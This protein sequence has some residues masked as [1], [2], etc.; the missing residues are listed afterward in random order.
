MRAE[1]LAG[2]V[3]ARYPDVVVARGEAT[4][5]V[6]RSELVDALASR[7]ILVRDRSHDP[8]CAGC[9]R[10][11]AGLVRHTELAIEALEG[12]CAVP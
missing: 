5:V 3:R 8:G 7:S 1:E 6:D 12:L 10:I 11:T 9:I 4:L 2:L